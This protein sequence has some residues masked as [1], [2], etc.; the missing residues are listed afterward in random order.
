[1]NRLSGK[2]AVPAGGGRGTGFASTGALPATGSRKMLSGRT[3]AGLSRAAAALNGCWLNG[4]AIHANG[5]WLL[6]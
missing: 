4:Q 2:I 1:M 6:H 3:K 5:A